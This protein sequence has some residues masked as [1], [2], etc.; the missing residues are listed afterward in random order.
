MRNKRSDRGPALSIASQNP[1]R[2]EQLD[3]LL[4]GTPSRLS[5]ARCYTGFKRPRQDMPA[6]LVSAEQSPSGNRM[7]RFSADH[8]RLVRDVL[9]RAY[10]DAQILTM[11]HAYRMY[12]RELSASE[13]P[14]ARSMSYTAF[15]CCV[16]TWI[17]SQTVKD[18]AG[19]PSEPVTVNVRK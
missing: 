14:D 9:N 3:A 7:P 1:A 5:T 18:G 12:C 11:R 2:E 19:A 4:S 8:E 13:L 17:R 15:H 16:R 10:A 6:R